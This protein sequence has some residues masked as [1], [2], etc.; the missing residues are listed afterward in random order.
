MKDI[1]NT[2]EFKAEI[3]N[4][5][6][7]QEAEKRLEQIHQDVAALDK[8]DQ[9]LNDFVT[10]IS[11]ICDKQ[12]ILNKSVENANKKLLPKENFERLSKSLNNFMQT[13]IA[14]V[15]AHENN[16]IEK[17]SS[18]ISEM[19]QKTTKFES[20]IMVLNEH[21]IVPKAFFSCVFMSFV[22]LVVFLLVVSYLN[23]NVVHSRILSYYILGVFSLLTLSNGGYIYYLIHK[24]ER[25]Y[26]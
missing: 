4:A 8:I 25:H 12:D 22:I 21:S 6:K 16:A 19:E 9:T 7:V 10:K 11:D 20:K 1:V 15:D 5:D 3:E 24:K 18:R 17:L 13:F 14:A 23:S 26:Y 2:E